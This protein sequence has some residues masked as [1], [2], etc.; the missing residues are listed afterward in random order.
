MDGNSSKVW[1]GHEGGGAWGPWMKTEAQH[2]DYT[3][4]EREEEAPPLSGG[5]LGPMACGTLGDA[6]LAPPRSLGTEVC[7]GLS[8]REDSSTG[9]AGVR[10]WE[11]VSG[12]KAM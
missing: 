11:G 6:C 7:W 4:A 1:Q 5:V 3:H 8:V 9:T 10:K 12:G 2:K